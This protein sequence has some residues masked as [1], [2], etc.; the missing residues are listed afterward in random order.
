L[1]DGKIAEE[2]D[3]LNERGGKAKALTTKDTKEHKGRSGDRKSKSLPRIN[4][5]ERESE[6]AKALTTK[7]TKEHKGRSGDLVIAVIG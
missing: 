4:T 1:D 5:D 7:D 3:M 2:A 6:K